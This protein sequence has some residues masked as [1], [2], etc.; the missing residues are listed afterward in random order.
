MF[1]GDLH[2]AGDVSLSD[3]TNMSHLE[4]KKSYSVGVEILDKQ[5]RHLLELINQ[6][7]DL[8]P[9]A[10]DRKG[11]FAVLNAF[12]EYAQTH[13]ETEEQY[14]KRYDFP[15]L[16]QHQ[17]EHVAF[18]ADVFRMAQQLENADPAIYTEVCRFVKDWY[19]SHVLG[20]DREYIDFLIAKDAK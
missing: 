14:L 9:K 7:S 19:I 12:A 4:W 6:L 20:T 5:H 3:E 10:G 17:R 11:L 13:F 16:A 8:G 1:V 15:G 2:A 18:T